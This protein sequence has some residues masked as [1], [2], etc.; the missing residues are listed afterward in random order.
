MRKTIRALLS[1]LLVTA[2]LFSCAIIN[3]SA[4]EGQCMILAETSGSG[5]IS[6]GT[7]RR[8]LIQKNYDIGSTVTLTA[9]PDD[10]WEFMYWE[11]TQSHRIISYDAEYTFYA[12]TL[13]TYN[14]VFELAEQTLVE[15]GLHHV[16]Y[17]TIGGNILYSEVIEIGE[18]DYPM[19]E[20]QIHIAGKTWKGW[21]YTQQQVAAME[22]NV[23]VQPV[24]TNDGSDERIIRWTIG[25]DVG[26]V[27]VPNESTQLLTAP[28]TMNGEKFSYWVKHG[29][30]LL[31]ED[32]IVCYTPNYSFIATVDTDVEAVYG[33]GE[34][35]GV[36]T[37]I[38][39]DVPNFEKTSI[40]FYAEHSVS[41]AYTVLQHGMLLTTRL[42][43]GNSD[44]KFVIESVDN[45]T[46]LKGTAKNTNSGGT[47]KA[48]LPGWHKLKAGSTTEYIYPLV[49]VRS[50]IIVKDADGV[51]HTIYSDI[52]CAD[53]INHDFVGVL[54]G[55]NYDDPFA[56]P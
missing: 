8:E 31:A 49:F 48:T 14:A 9:I 39:G 38:A 25:N 6:D 43:I 15:Q 13:A 11:N 47:Y 29:E 45:T 10:G 20:E 21:E 37:F 18:V 32:T 54:E 26:S 33:K 22:S 53:Y 27:T 3:A 51:S 55:D 16:I 36:A 2:M 4:A 5:E 28:A 44:S 41:D 35:S 17:L 19:P 50:Y 1:V 24:Y 12:A 7:L 34:G 40:T 52:Y 46:V 30:G 23:Y 56:N 42:D